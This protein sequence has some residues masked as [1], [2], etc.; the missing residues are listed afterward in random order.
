VKKWLLKNQPWEVTCFLPSV[1]LSLKTTPQFATTHALQA[2]TA[3]PPLGMVPRTTHIH[4]T[5]L[6]RVRG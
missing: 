2:R 6:T 4:S 1:E 3:Q 5:C